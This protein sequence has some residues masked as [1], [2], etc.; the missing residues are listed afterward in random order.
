M[1]PIESIDKLS[2][3]LTEKGIDH[4]IKRE[5]NPEEF[6]GCNQIRI[7]IYR[8]LRNGLISAICH[9]GSYGF[10]EGLIEVWNTIEE[11]YGYLSPEEAAG[12][13]EGMIIRKE[14]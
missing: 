11:P 3:L 13:I 14:Y 7:D 8:K 1:T 5:G 12:L 10:E 2:Q 9:R 4:K 6:G